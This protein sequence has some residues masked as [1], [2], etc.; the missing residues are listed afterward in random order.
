VNLALRRVAS[1]TGRVRL[2]WVDAVMALGHSA[3]GPSCSRRLL[4]TLELGSAAYSLVLSRAWLMAG[5]GPVTHT[6]RARRVVPDE[7][8]MI[9]VNILLTCLCIATSSSVLE[10]SRCRKY[11]S[12]AL[13]SCADDRAANGHERQTAQNSLRAAKR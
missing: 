4:R 8:N 5:A 7:R 2:Q 11:A 12:V 3:S 13:C 10:K 1:R 9:G 6:G